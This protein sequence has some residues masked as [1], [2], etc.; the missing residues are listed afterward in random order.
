M[1]LISFKSCYLNVCSPFFRSCHVYRYAGV[2]IGNFVDVKWSIV[3]PPD[4]SF[5]EWNEKGV[6]IDV[7][8]CT[9][10]MYVAHCSTLEITLETMIPFCGF[11]LYCIL[12]TGI[13]CKGAQRLDFRSLRFSW[14]L[15]HKVSMDGNFEVKIISFTKFCSSFRPRNSYAFAQS[16]FKDSF[17]V[18][19]KTIL[20]RGAFETIC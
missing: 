5:S 11:Y 13:V 14:F 9:L 1:N 3:H 20:F 15:H 10:C 17:W 4:H 6:C 7:Q 2:G 19:A 16:N 8:Q 18:S 12:A